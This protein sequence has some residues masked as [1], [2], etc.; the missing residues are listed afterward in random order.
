MNSELPPWPEIKSAGSQVG[1]ILRTENYFLYRLS[2][3]A[4]AE[5]A[6]E[7]ACIGELEGSPA[8]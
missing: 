7:A 5:P 3:D 4:L 1:A 2:Y 6:S 8:P